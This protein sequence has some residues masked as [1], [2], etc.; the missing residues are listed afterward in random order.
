MLRD[1]NAEKWSDHQT[2]KFFINK[3]VEALIPLKEGY[4]GLLKLRVPGS[5]PARTEKRKFP[6]SKFCLEQCEE[7][8]QDLLKS[9]IF[10]GGGLEG[11]NEKKI[12]NQIYSNSVIKWKRTWNKNEVEM[13]GET[14]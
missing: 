12:S 1:S 7:A 3:S 2:N 13:D 9:C 11:C 5:V 6:K 14:K 10:F 8:C 4:Q